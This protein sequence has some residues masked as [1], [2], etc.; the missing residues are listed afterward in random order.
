MLYN[1]NLCN[2]EYKSYQSLWNHNK[3]K[4]NEIRV[5]NNNKE[6]KF[7]CDTCNKKFRR[8]A[9]LKYHKNNTC[10]NNIILKNDDI[11]KINILEN[12][13]IELKNKINN[14]SNNIINNKNNS[15]ITNNTNNNCNV[16]NGTV[17]IYINKTG[18]EN[19]L[20][21]N[22]SEKNEIFNKEIYGI[23]SF[24]K[25]INFNERLPNNHS[26]CTKSLEGKYLLSYNTEEEK[27]ES[28]RKKYFYYELLTNSVEKMEIL[29]KSCKNNFSKEKQIKVENTIQSLKELKDKDYS[30]KS[31]KDIKNKLIDISYNNREIVLNTWDNPNN[32]IQSMKIPDDDELLKQL[33]DCDTSG[34]DSNCFLPINNSDDSLSESETDTDYILKFTRKKSII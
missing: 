34:N 1:C 30:N 20:E 6:C 7:S 5:I 17:N 13:I 26:F 2:K 12:E 22:D 21:L 19:V 23:V 11:N 29:Y 16:N 27:I 9:N 4:H 32:N 31:L 25:F 15:N 33:E 3:I 28:V 14:I 8:N 10:K 24:I 18:T